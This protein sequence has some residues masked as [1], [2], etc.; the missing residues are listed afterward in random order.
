MIKLGFI[1]ENAANTDSN[2]RILLY[3]MW[4]ILDG[5]EKDEVLIDDLKVLIMG[6]AKVTDQKRVGTDHEGVTTSDYKHIGY[7]NKKG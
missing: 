2:E 4:K 5:E 1:S 6:I 3:D 7:T